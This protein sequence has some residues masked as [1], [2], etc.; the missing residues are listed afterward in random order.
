MYYFSEQ[1]QA[2]SKLSRRYWDSPPS[3]YYPLS[4]CSHHSGV[5][6][7]ISEL[8]RHIGVTIWAI[9]CIRSY[10]WYNVLWTWQNVH[11]C[12][13]TTTMPY[14]SFITQTLCHKKPSTWLLYLVPLASGCWSFHCLRWFAFSRMSYR[15]ANTACLFLRSAFPLSIICLSFLHFFSKLKSWA[16]FFLTLNNIPLSGFI[17]LGVIIFHSCTRS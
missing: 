15:L 7:I 2:H 10:F 11:W 12:V 17:I 9:V 14:S 6:V 13:P 3:T 1:V 5:L 16:D 4:Q 8:T